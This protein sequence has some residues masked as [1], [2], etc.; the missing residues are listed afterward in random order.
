MHYKPEMINS[1][2]LFYRITSAQPTDNTSAQPLPNRA[3]GDSFISNFPNKLLFKPNDCVGKIV[4]L[5]ILKE[6]FVITLL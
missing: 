5:A 1:Y 3:T 6:I 2:Q 4:E